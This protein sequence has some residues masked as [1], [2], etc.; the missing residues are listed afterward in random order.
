MWPGG[1]QHV[2]FPESYVCMPSSGL[3]FEVFVISTIFGTFSQIRLWE[4]IWPG[5]SIILG[6]NT[7]LDVG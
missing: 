4:G 1:T 6:L 7:I 5:G 2:L 3:H